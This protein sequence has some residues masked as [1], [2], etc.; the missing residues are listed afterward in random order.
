MWR[1]VTMEEDAAARKFY[2]K[3]A[4]SY[5][6]RQWRKGLWQGFILGAVTIYGAYL[7]FG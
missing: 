4:E 2:R 7:M 3:T 6:F 1:R 5:G